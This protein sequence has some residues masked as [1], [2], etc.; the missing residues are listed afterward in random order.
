MHVFFWWKA[1]LYFTIFLQDFT[2]QNESAVKYPK[3]VVQRPIRNFLPSSQFFMSIVCWGVEMNQN[4]SVQRR[5]QKKPSHSLNH[6][7]VKAC[8]QTNKS[9]GDNE[10]IAK[11]FTCL[12]NHW[13]DSSTEIPAVYN[14]INKQNEHICFH[15]CNKNKWH[16][17]GIL[18][19]TY[20][21]LVLQ[22]LIYLN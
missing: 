22:W 13:K 18:H 12:Q 21:R 16:I 11:F 9:I 8:H 2:G 6:T 15:C 1:K 10:D 14:N 5:W 7:T 19:P 3:I 4:L 17:W 20:T